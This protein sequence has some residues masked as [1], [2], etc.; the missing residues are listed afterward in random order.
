MREDV[1]GRCTEELLFRN[2]RH[3]GVGSFLYRDS[4]DPLEALVFQLFRMR[5]KTQWYLSIESTKYRK[6]WYFL[7]VCPDA[8]KW[9]SVLLL[10]ELV[11]S[12]GR[13][14]QKTTNRTGLLTRTLDDLLEIGVEGPPLPADDTID[15]W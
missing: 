15:L 1:S 4:T 7:H 14:E 11:F 3:E 9:P 6:V 12:N 2:N 8:E 13:V 5:L 10:C